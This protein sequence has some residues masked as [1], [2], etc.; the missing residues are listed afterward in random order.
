MLLLAVVADGAA[1]E[2]DDAAAA[3]LETS[4]ECGGKLE[5]EEVEGGAMPESAEAP[6]PATNERLCVDNERSF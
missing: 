1:A 4:R 6:L 2:A 5:E 3:G